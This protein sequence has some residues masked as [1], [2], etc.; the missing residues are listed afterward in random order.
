[1][2]KTETAKKVHPLALTPVES[3]NLHSV[4]YCA[5]CESIYVRFKNK[6]G[7]PTGFYKY[8]KAGKALFDELMDEKTESKGSFFHTKVRILDA[9]RLKDYE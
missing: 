3:K 1:M 2:E 7:A 5:D 4:G 9:K 8:P 6:D